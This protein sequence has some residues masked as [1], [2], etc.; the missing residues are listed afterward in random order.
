MFKILTYFLFIIIF[1]IKN[2]YAS[3]SK[4]LNVSQLLVK[5][6]GWETH[7]IGPFGQ[8]Y[9]LTLDSKGDSILD[10]HQII[11]RK[12]GGNKSTKIC[13]IFLIG[14]KLIIKNEH[15]IKTNYSQ[16]KAKKARREYVLYGKNLSEKEWMLSD[17]FNWLTVIAEGTNSS[18]PTQEIFNKVLT[19]VDCDNF[20]VFVKYKNNKIKFPNR[21]LINPEYLFL[22]MVN[23]TSKNSGKIKDIFKEM[24]SLVD[25]NIK[26]IKKGSNYLIK[27]GFWTNSKEKLFFEKLAKSV[28]PDNLMLAG[29]ICELKGTEVCGKLLVSLDKAEDPNQWLTD[30][31]NM[32]KQNKK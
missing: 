23:V 13:E 25:K 3:D 15:L 14:R 28:K 30:L 16:E 12:F 8:F 9:T 32:I 10:L 18:S 11:K 29:D 24:K 17:Q 2:I 21:I 31:S 20:N 5:N 7:E 27:V 4:F 19:V 1:L 26:N 22:D 6:Y